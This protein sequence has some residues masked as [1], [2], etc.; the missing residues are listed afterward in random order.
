VG[1]EGLRL[2]AEHRAADDFEA[3][4]FQVR[5]ICHTAKCVVRIFIIL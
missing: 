5:V 3:A 4:G 1:Y 2:S